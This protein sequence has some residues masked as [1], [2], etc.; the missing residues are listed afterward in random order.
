MSLPSVSA[1]DDRYE[2]L[3]EFHKIHRHYAVP[4]KTAFHGLA[5]W[6]YNQRRYKDKLLPEQRQ[7][8]DDIGFNWEIATKKNKGS[9][10]KGLKWNSKYQQMKGFY[11]KFGHC[12]VPSD[13]NNDL[14]VW[15]NC[16]RYYRRHGRLDDKVVKL[17]DDINFCWELDDFS[18]TN[19]H[20]RQSNSG[21]SKTASVV[22]AYHTGDPDAQQAQEQGTKRK[23]KEALEP[24]SNVNYEQEDQ[25]IQSDADEQ[26]ELFPCPSTPVLMVNNEH[27]P[28]QDT[29]VVESFSQ[30]KVVCG[31]KVFGVGDVVYVRREDKDNECCQGIYQ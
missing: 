3:K 24:T 13:F 29:F 31:S 10:K 7:K 8:L 17:L 12:I 16:Q 5:M 28:E 23:H 2:E 30:T 20:T 26:Q 21:T 1:W 18:P 19:R 15:A 25:G 9:N 4:Q 11:E 6:V 22:T 14:R 27:E